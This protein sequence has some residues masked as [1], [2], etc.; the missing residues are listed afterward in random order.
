MSE[1]LA[2]KESNEISPRD[3]ILRKY[4][5]VAELLMTAGSYMPAIE[6]TWHAIHVEKTLLGARYRF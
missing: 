3:E 5:V 4:E 6:M 2:N 1:T